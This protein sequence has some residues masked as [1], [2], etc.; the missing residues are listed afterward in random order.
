MATYS[1]GVSVSV[2]G[3]P[4][5]E[6][7]GLSWTLG[8]TLDIGRDSP[9]P[10]SLGSMTLECLG[11]PFSG[12]TAPNGFFGFYYRLV[13]LVISGGGLDLT[14]DAYCESMDAV[15]EVN[16]VTRYTLTFKIL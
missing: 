7:T 3:S 12:V 11:R 8:G 4:L 1:Q 14:C 5:V 15:G 13:E 9:L 6:V 16:G 10:T 2:D